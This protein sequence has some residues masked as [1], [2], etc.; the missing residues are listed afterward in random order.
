MSTVLWV[1]VTACVAILVVS[2]QQYRLST[3]RSRARILS[4]QVA[5]AYR[6]YCDVAHQ[7]R[8]T[9]PTLCKIL[10]PAG[11]IEAHGGTQ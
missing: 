2:Y 10:G 4:D 6:M 5:E 1:V 3:W 11:L 9:R 7:E 8:Q